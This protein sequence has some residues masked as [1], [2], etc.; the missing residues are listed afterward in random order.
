MDFKSKG[1]AW[2]GDIY[3]RF[4]TICHEVDNIVNQD[5]VKYV[6]N[7]VHTVSKSMKKLCSEVVQVVDPVRCEAQSVALKGNAAVGGYIK[8]MI[9]IEE[10][11]GHTSSVNQL[12]IKSS[13]VYTTKIHQPS[14]AF[15]G[16][17]LV[18]QS[19]TTASGESL[20]G[21]NS[22]S[23]LENNEYYDLSTEE[24]AIKEKFNAPEVLEL[25]FPNEKKSL[26][27][28]LSSEFVD[29]NN[30]NAC[31]S[32]D[33]VL[34]STIFDGEEFQSPQEVRTAF[35]SP[36]NDSDT[37]SD[38]SGSL[39]LSE[40]TNS[41]NNSAC[42][43]LDEI[44]PS[45][46]VDGEVFNSPQNM[47]ND[48][49]TVSGASEAI[50]LSEFSDSNNESAC[51]PDNI[52][53]S[54]L[55]EREELQLPQKMGTVCYSPAHDSGTI[56][57]AS[58]AVA[59]SELSLSVASSCGSIFTEPSTLPENSFNG[60][61]TK[62]VSCGNPVDV[63]AHDSETANLLLSSSAAPI[64]SSTTEVAD[65]GF[66]CSNSVLSL[67]SA[68][69]SNDF[70]Y[71]SDDL[72]GPGMETI[73]LSDKVKLEESCVMVDNSMLYEASRRIHKHR[74]FKKKFQDVF[75]SKKRLS[76]E[77]EQLAIWFWDLDTESKQDTTQ[78]Q[79]PSSSTLCLDP[80]LQV[81]DC[82]WELL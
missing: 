74:S 39:V 54:T 62:V 28:T 59:L 49:D 29:S 38:A 75:N 32:L 25:V 72:E 43:S 51:V 66:T 65:T 5:P 8:S 14:N 67:E 15:G 48:S 30:D 61:L 80:D 21:G 55:V 47:G 60:I 81:L 36:P 82:E 70:S 6:E 2:V 44:S 52:V 33:E 18:D 1:I 34:P 17:D 42:L 23:A 11:R 12:I 78:H 40:F 64:V 57:D 22:D 76:K 53:P 13:D 24:D 45:T 37:V 77:Y 41:N 71:V 46:L 58:S 73:D 4:E 63:S 3:Q 7:Q 26:I 68:G 69:C 50:F 35:Y 31:V 16:C 27:K 10:D 56:S 20:E 79:L 19:T 9:G